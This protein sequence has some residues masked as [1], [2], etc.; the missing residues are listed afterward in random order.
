MHLTPPPSL[1]VH[2]EQHGVLRVQSNS[3]VG[4]SVGISDGVGMQHICSRRAAWDP[5]TTHTPPLSLEQ[6]TVNN[7]GFFVCNNSGEDMQYPS[8]GT[9]NGSDVV[10]EGPL[11]TPDTKVYEPCIRARLGTTAHV[12]I[13]FVLES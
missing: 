11:P 9:G 4:D 7:A 13:F 12:C 1:A 10:W 6:C 8:Y 5:H 3:W 2:G